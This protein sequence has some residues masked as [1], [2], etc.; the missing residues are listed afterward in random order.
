MSDGNDGVPDGLVPAEALASTTAVAV[1]GLG[2]VRPGKDKELETLVASILPLARAEQGCEQYLVHAKRD[3]PGVYAFYERWANGEDL[4]RHV[5]Q[6][7]VQEYFVALF[8]LL[9]PGFET[10]WLWPLEG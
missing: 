4:L 10:K 3:E 8:G 5:Q 1:F 7:F 9:E 6:P 2:R